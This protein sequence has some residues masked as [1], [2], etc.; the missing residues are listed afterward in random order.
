MHDWSGGNLAVFR[1]L[2]AGALAPVGFVMPPAVGAALMLPGRK[3]LAEDR[4]KYG[5]F[6]MGIQ[7]YSLRGF[8]VER[9]MYLTVLHRLFEPGSDRTAE[10]RRRDGPVP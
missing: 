7:S 1:R 4:K 3:S 9:A 6:R 2:A 5:G 10:R 8:P